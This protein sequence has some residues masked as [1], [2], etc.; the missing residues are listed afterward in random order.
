LELDGVIVKQVYS[1]HGP[2]MAQPLWIKI[3]NP[4]T[5][6]GKAEESGLIRNRLEGV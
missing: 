6:S 3:K 1:L 4:P 2:M 5:A